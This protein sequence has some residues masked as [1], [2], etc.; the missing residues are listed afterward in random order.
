MP[1]AF[2]IEDL[3]V[4][5]ERGNEVNEAVRGVSL[6]VDAGEC[7]ALV[8][9]SG[10]GKTLL[11]TAALGLAS[12]QARIQGSVKLFGEELLEAAPSVLN[13]V[14]GGKIAMV[15][16]DPMQALTPHLRIGVQLM[17]VLKRHHGL[18]GEAAVSA[19]LAMLERVGVSEAQRRFRQYPHQLSGGQRQRVLI[20]MALLCAPS[21]LVADE[22]TTALDVSLQAQILTLLKDFKRSSALSLIFISHDLAVVADIA[23]RVMVMYAGRIV[24]SAPAGALLRS[25]RHPYSAALIA[26]MPRL[27][28]PPGER[29]ASLP[30]YP[31]RLGEAAAGCAFAPRCPRVEARC[32]IERPPLTRAGERSV[33]C[34][35]P[36]SG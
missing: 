14:R 13:R 27:Q 36:E 23:D 3:K 26:C 11:F 34:H 9:E 16:Q 8:G 18:N 24:E 1:A 15:F 35:F 6:E 2:S 5:F 32:R 4:R 25:P 12:R 22:P 20:A 17:E 7:L 29:M 19:A 31:P 33:A 30:G 28:G 10:A 21:V